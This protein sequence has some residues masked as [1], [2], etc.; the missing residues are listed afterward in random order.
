MAAPAPGDFYANPPLPQDLLNDPV[1]NTA[2]VAAMRSAYMVTTGPDRNLRFTYAH[3]AAA[4][5]II[6]AP[7]NAP[8][9]FE[10][11]ESLANLAVN[12]RTG[13]QHCVRCRCAAIAHMV[14]TAAQ[15]AVAAHAIAFPA[16]HTTLTTPFPPGYTAPQGFATNQ[17]AGT[18]AP[19]AIVAP[20]VGPAVVAAVVAPVPVP[21]VPPG[22]APA[23]A[24]LPVPG[25]VPAPAPVPMAAAA[26][27]VV[28]A[29]GVGAPLAPVPPG[30]DPCT[31]PS[32]KPMEGSFKVIMSLSDKMVTHKWKDKESASQ[33]VTG[34]EHL[35]SIAPLDERHWIYVLYNM[36]PASMV[37][38]RMW[39]HSHIILS[40]FS[41][42]QAKLLFVAQFQHGNFKQEM[43]DLY[44]TCRQGAN[45]AVQAYAH[46]FQGIANNLE[47]LETAPQTIAD[48]TAGLLPRLQALIN[49]HRVM[50][51]STT[52]NPAWDYVDVSAVATLAIKFDTDRFLSQRGDTQAAP[53]Y[54]RNS[55]YANPASKTSSSTTSKEKGKDK[56]KKRKASKS[57]EPKRSSSDD[58]M[59]IHHPSSTTHTTV[60]CRN[61]GKSPEK[62]KEKKKSSPQKPS[63]AP[64]A[65]G[66]SVPR[67]SARLRERGSGGQ[68]RDLSTV[69]CYTCGQTGHYSTTCT[70]RA[71]AP[72]SYQPPPRR[73]P[74][75]PGSIKGEAIKRANALHFEPMNEQ[76]EQE[77]EKEREEKRP[78]LKSA[79]KK[80][81]G[82][83]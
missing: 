6:V 5:E 4:P 26:A 80:P 64:A 14:E 59:C 76:D 54:M 37:V 2:T 75:P 69:T 61:G 42:N 65:M 67:Q 53:A 19:I 43:D 18:I 15:A 24:P 78:A 35:V 47:Y 1:A 12:P 77:E 71:S 60:Q 9:C 23:P 25:P 55:P 45:E 31:L 82:P 48:F 38:K 57:P 68:G 30:V 58:P 72:Q 36:I 83:Q 11:R 56:T 62:E 66:S 20:P 8:C 7:V 16:T 46:R 49:Q 52:G 39:V 17:P 32:V 51:Q 21:G 50:M 81:R 22:P 63:Q 10:T 70:N 74:P 40:R 79:M 33:F 44:R 29:P 13:A 27:A 28:G 41:W 73:P 34:V 3:L